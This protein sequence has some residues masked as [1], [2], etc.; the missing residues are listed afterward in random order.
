MK[1]TFAFLALATLVGCT[2]AQCSQAT[3]IGSKAKVTCYSGGTLVYE[4]VS[5][6]KVMTE[7]N[8]DGWYFREEGT[9]DLVRT[10]AD[11]IVRN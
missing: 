6:G 4:G 9:G 10:N 8:S 7:S 2:Q 3:T 1:K 5:T 11:C